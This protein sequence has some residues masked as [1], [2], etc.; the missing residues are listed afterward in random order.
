MVKP[1]L[2]TMNAL[3]LCNHQSSWDPAMHFMGLHVHSRICL[4]QP[5][6][7]TQLC[8]SVVLA[9]RNAYGQVR[10]HVPC[11]LQTNQ[12]SWHRTWSTGIGLQGDLCS[13]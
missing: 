3:S 11:D 8:S 5:L 1:A 9:P 2:A 10:Q 6:V 12:A 7:G 4:V 13:T